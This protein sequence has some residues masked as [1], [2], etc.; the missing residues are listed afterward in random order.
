MADGPEVIHYRFRL[1]RALAATW[2][3]LNDILLDGE[4]GLE[5][6]TGRLKI[7]DAVTPWNDLAYVERG[8]ELAMLGDVDAAGKADRKAVVWS[9]ADQK[10]V[11]GSAGASYV[12]GLGIDIDDTDPDAPVISSTLGSIALSGRV[13]DYASLPGGLGPGDAGQAYLVED[14]GLIYVWDGSAFPSSGDGVSL[15]TSSFVP[16]SPHTRV[17]MNFNPDKSPNYLYPA[18][19]YPELG[20]LAW[21]LI[22]PPVVSGDGQGLDFA[23]NN[24]VRHL[25]PDYSFVD[26]PVGTL[27]TVDAWIR[28][29]STSSASY[30]FTTR[31]YSGLGGFGL[32]VEPGGQVFL[33]DTAG[34]SGSSSN[35][36]VVGGTYFVRARA[37]ET[38][39]Q[40][41]V[42]GAL[43]LSFPRTVA[44][45][46]HAC[47]VGYSSL[48]TAAPAHASLVIYSL[49]VKVGV[50]EPG[51]VV[52]AGYDLD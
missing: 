25:A 4:F 10:H 49:R 26:V 17:R 11:Y 15:Q 12:P 30:I 29:N 32:R 20:H 40:V 31:R 34:A 39:W 51:A 5:K 33:F 27:A 6:D 52:P 41:F 21:E 38:H 46:A 45:P 43:W 3:A 14:D 44:G 28:V 47:D 35:T 24:G 23:G 1:R 36:L 16:L 48:N 9:D 22:R 18:A 8:L 19:R 37:T 50:A 2:V 42:N 7:G 13:A